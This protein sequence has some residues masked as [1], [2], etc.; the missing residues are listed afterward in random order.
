MSRKK[1]SPKKDQRQKPD[2]AAALVAKSSS[3]SFPVVAIQPEPSAKR[4]G[5]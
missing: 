1:S 4:R 5:I 3:V 2:T